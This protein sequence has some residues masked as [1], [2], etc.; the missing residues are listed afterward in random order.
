MKNLLPTIESNNTITVTLPND[1]SGLNV[2]RYRDHFELLACTQHK[3]VVL[4]FGDTDFIDSSG[5]GAMVFL[6]KRIEQRG[7]LMKII[8]AK[9]Q[10]RELMQL[11]KVDLTIPFINSTETD[12]A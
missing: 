10:P 2:D 7:T 8:D 11:L 5:I 12:L 9:G 3:T 1:F 4:N 6:Y